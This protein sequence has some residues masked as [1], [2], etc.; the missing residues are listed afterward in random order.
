MHIYIY[1][2]TKKN[3]I[4]HC[5]QYYLLVILRNTVPK[6]S[7]SCNIIYVNRTLFR[8]I[9]IIRFLA[10]FHNPDYTF[11]LHFYTSYFSYVEQQV[12]PFPC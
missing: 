3:M 5:T 10:N 9:C 11:L 4:W 1:D 6:E 12:F 8:F 2:N 7:L